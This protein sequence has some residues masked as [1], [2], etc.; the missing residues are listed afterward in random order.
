MP[1]DA[2]ASGVGGTLDVLHRR[3]V[4][5]GGVGAFVLKDLEALPDAFDGL[6]A[7]VGHAG[8]RNVA[9][10]IERGE[11]AERE[12]GAGAGDVY[13]QVASLFEGVLA[14]G[15]ALGHDDDWVGHFV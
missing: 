5:L 12:V 6:G 3:D 4:E 2:A 7:G 15:L 10:G 9:V 8:D 11:L 13:Q 14:L 1:Q